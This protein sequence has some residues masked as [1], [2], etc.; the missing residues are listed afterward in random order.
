MFLWRGRTE[1]R[2]HLG[3]W[4]FPRGNDIIETGCILFPVQLYTSYLVF[5]GLPH[6]AFMNITH[7]WHNKYALEMHTDP[8]PILK[9]VCVNQINC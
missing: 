7:S 5:K 6:F 9:Y 1:R 3:I 4:K 8:F 2:A